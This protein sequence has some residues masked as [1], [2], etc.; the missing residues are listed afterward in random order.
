LSDLRAPMTDILKAF[1]AQLT[2]LQ[3]YKARYG[4]LDRQTNGRV[5]DIG[6]TSSDGSDTEQE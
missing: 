1:T 3:Q 5:R 2:E 4:P 6:E